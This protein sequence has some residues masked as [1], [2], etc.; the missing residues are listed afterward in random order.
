[1]H[2]QD[3][4]RLQELDE[5]EARYR[6]RRDNARWYAV[7]GTLMMFAGGINA[8][9]AVGGGLMTLYGLI[10]WGVWAR[11]LGK[12]EA[13]QWDALDI[14]DPFGPQAFDEHARGAGQRAS[15]DESAEV[16]GGPSYPWE[17]D[18]F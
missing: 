4:Q 14:D 13:E 6:Q 9:I 18:N 10:A 11:R 17:R 3:E 15:R 1:M 2:L 7:M 12:V 16:P 5:M 8:G